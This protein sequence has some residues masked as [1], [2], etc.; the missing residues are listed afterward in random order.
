MNDDFYQ[1][2]V[3][4]L[5]CNY[6]YKK[7]WALDHNFDAQKIRQSRGNSAFCVNMTNLIRQLYEMRF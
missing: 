6:L 5:S 3:P 4:R 7:L 2:Y 1:R